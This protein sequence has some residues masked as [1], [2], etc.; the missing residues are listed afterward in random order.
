MNQDIRTQLANCRIAGID[1]GLKRVGIAVCDEL[2]IS[3]S[4]KA[5]L[6]YTQSTFWEQCFDVLNKE[7]V[8]AIVVGNPIRKGNIESKITESIT[9]F[10]SILNAD[11]KFIIFRQDESMSSINAMDTMLI[12]GTKK[13]AR[14][15]K[16]NID[17]VAAAIIL[18]DFLN[19]N[20]W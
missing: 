16:G 1:F 8:N 14:R 19:E 17:K 3:I 18:K 20:L 6:D 4:P 5:V 13:K 10:I 2:H 9:E 11:N 7:R 15:E 12:N